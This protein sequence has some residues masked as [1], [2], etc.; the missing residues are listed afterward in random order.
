ML[1]PDPGPTRP[2]PRPRRP[3]WL[4]AVA[5]LA[6]VLVAAA[7]WWLAPGLTPPDAAFELQPLPP[8]PMGVR[9]DPA[10][11]ARRRA[12]AARDLSEPVPAESPPGRDAAFDRRL[13]QWENGRRLLFAL[14]GKLTVVGPELAEY[15]VAALTG[16]PRAIFDP[17]TAVVSPDGRRV[18][19][20]YYVDPLPGWLS[21]DP[22]PEPALLVLD[23]RTGRTDRPK[24]A[25]DPPV[26]LD[27]GG[28]LDGVGWRPMPQWIGDTVLTVSAHARPKPTGRPGG[29]SDA[30]PML[31]RYD[32]AQSGGFREIGGM[33][34]VFSL[35]A[36]RSP[37]LLVEG[38]D[39]E[40]FAGDPPPRL[41]RLDAD[42]LHPAGADDRR[43]FDRIERAS[44]E[45]YQWAHGPG[46]VSRSFSYMVG[47]HRVEHF[48]WP[49][50]GDGPWD[51]RHVEVL[52][53]NDRLV[54]RLP[55]RL[56]VP[57]P[58]LLSAEDPLI[59]D[60]RWDADLGLYRWL[61]REPDGHRY[62]TFVADAAGH[63][64]RWHSGRYVGPVALAPR[65]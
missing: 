36:D 57:F 22:W 25:S 5:L 64:R 63:V 39:R 14:P 21:N 29:D 15:P 52:R 28:V 31:L 32:A 23:L 55:A 50:L 48:L 3:L 46:S 53:L 56:C 37:S 38:S 6:C 47:R 20:L 33:P 58:L 65:P 40:Y 13:G 34:R 43:R 51:G 60:V 12:A 61:E 30:R 54:R 49:S 27:H 16:D 42:G 35:T 24:P 41:Y 8:P 44:S 45:A 19:V 62:D 18:A 4:P 2:D 11:D 1:S 26:R 10:A 9:S 7:G 17:R 59:S